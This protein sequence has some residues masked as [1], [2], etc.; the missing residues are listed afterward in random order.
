M[1]KEAN[2]SKLFGFE[3]AQK[4]YLEK[5]SFATFNC[6]TATFKLQRHIAK[7]AFADVIEQLYKI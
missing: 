6:V 3:K 5:N 2:D 1:E 7:K 4:I